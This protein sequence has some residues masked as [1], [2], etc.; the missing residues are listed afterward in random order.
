MFKVGFYK[1]P[2]EIP[3]VGIERFFG[4]MVRQSV[5]DCKRYTLLEVSASSQLTVMIA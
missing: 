3:K 4:M 2:P 1:V 5:N